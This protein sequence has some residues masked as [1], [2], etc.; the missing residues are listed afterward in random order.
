[1]DTVYPGLQLDK[2]MYGQPYTYSE[3]GKVYSNVFGMLRNDK[4]VPL[5]GQYDPKRGDIIIG[6][7]NEEKFSGYSVYINLP[8]EGS[9]SSRDSREEL[10]TGDV[11]ECEVD[12][13][14]EIKQVSLTNPKKLGFGSVMIIPP[15]K[16]PRVIGKQMSM[17]NLIKEKTGCDIR[18]GK[19]GIL[20]IND[21]K[22]KPI[23][24]KTINKILREAQFSGLTSRIGEFLDK[25]IK[26]K[27]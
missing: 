5:Q 3:N 9:L 22:N 26:N 10:E 25:E 11:I 8:S 14:N 23:V 6:V 12:Y 27:E 24:I 16:V 15:V 17:I 18:M 4:I 21:C 20:W 1:M 13:V 7:V 2:S 19:N